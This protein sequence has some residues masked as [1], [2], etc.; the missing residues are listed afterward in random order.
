M[1]EDTK[2]NDYI[3]ASFVHVSIAVNQVVEELHY[4]DDE[5]QEFVNMRGACYLML[6]CWN[7]HIQFLDVI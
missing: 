5:F 6:H 1:R 7:S 2:K 3:N 4:V